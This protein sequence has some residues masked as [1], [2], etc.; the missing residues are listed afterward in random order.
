MVDEFFENEYLKEIKENLVYKK[1]TYFNDGDFNVC[2]HLR[3]PNSCDVPTYPEMETYLIYKNADD[4]K[5]FPPK[6]CH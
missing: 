3:S 4:I 5:K 6:N 1:K 2:L